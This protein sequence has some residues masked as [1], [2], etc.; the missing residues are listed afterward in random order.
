MKTPEAKAAAE[1]L[2]SL[3]STSDVAARL[4]VKPNV[5]GNWKA[6][7]VPAKYAARIAK[8]AKVEAAAIRS[9]CRTCG[10]PFA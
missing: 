6:R 8:L 7:G 3:G 2:D 10:R 1:A 9:R 5:V 4:G